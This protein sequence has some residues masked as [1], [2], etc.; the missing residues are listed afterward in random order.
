MFK[1][2]KYIGWVYLITNKKT[3]QLYVGQT[4]QSIKIRY[5][6]HLKLTQDSCRIDRAINKHGVDAFDIT[7][8]E[9]VSAKSIEEY[10]DLINDR[11][12]YWISFYNT[13]EDDF[14]YNCTPGGSDYCAAS[15]RHPILVY[16]IHGELIKKYD[17]IRD[18]INDLDLVNVAWVAKVLNNPD[19]YYRW[20]KKYILREI[21]NPLTD[22]D[23]KKL[24]ELY[25]KCFQYDIDGNLINEFETRMDAW[26]YLSKNGCDV[27]LRKF[28][29][30]SRGYCG[31]YVGGYIWRVD[32][33][34]FNSFPLPKQLR[35]VE[36][37]DSMSG[38][39]IAVFNNV[40]EASQ[41]TGIAKQNIW[42]CCNPKQRKKSAGGYYWCYGG[43]FNLAQF[44]QSR[45]KSSKAKVIQDA[46]MNDVIYAFDIF[47]NYITDF[48][49]VQ[50]IKERLIKVEI[51][52]IIL[53]CQ[54]QDKIK[55]YKRLIWKFKSDV[56]DIFSYKRDY[57]RSAKIKS[58]I[59]DNYN[60]FIVQLSL[61][62]DYIS[63]YKTSSEAALAVNGTSSGIGSV[64]RG[65]TVSYHGYKWINLSDYYSN[66][67]Y[68]V[69]H[70]INQ[71]EQVIYSKTR[72]C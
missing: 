14:H 66:N 57:L 20:N 41:Q 10:T 67:S 53:C 27:T 29:A 36:Q 64:C 54:S 13:Y 30:I 24:L 25:P 69:S 71:F 63:L 50:D 6:Q 52:Q 12:R 68:I 56:G 70:I 32:P 39:L 37:R 62:G 47:G 38:E 21:D 2:G 5:Q 61:E 31:G 7:E 26:D 34:D 49:G 43:A 16:T 22:D 1:Q 11:E 65:I 46:R 72:R 59:K 35:V 44:K 33:D 51:R 9:E 28:D 4:G 55:V 17:S 60:N 58:L 3:G 40:A 45:K 48:K 15:Q 8:I 23:I 19:K 18:S 42:S